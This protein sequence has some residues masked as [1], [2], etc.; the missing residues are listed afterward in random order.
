MAHALHIARVHAE[1]LDAAWASLHDDVARFGSQNNY[2]HPLLA[3]SPDGE[4]TAYAQR[5][6]DGEPPPDLNAW[7]T[8]AQ[9]LRNAWEF[10]FS[11]LPF[12][13]TDFSPI[14]TW[15][16]RRKAFAER[17]NATATSELRA[18]FIALAEREEALREELAWVN[19]TEA[20]PFVPGRAPDAWPV[21]D[22]PGSG[23]KYLLLFDA[24]VSGL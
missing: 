14:D 23:A 21:R 15:V 7:R 8:E 6:G 20:A 9:W 10:V 16:A 12:S 18:L 17:L 11:S 24:H 2:A 22:V 3:L 4:L 13:E 1:S 5:E 19:E